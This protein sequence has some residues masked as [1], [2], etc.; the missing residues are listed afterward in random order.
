MYAS[1]LTVTAFALAALSAPVHA[2]TADIFHATLG[3]T[4]PTVDIST[5]EMRQVLEDG[6][7]LIIDTRTVAEFESGHIPGAKLVERT[8]KT[9]VATVAKITA[10]NKAAKLVLYCNGPYCQASRNLAH[11]L[12]AAGYTNVTRYQLGVP[13]WRALGGGPL[14]VEQN[15]VVQTFKADRTAIFVDTRSAAEFAKSTLPNALNIPADELAAGKLKRLPLPDDDFN[16]RIVLFGNDGTQARK[17]A[18]ALS[19]RP[20]HNVAYF[21]GRLADLHAALPAH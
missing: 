21:S 7:A 13:V 15:W 8:S 11:D 1:I 3:E 6:S 12:V 20:W 14:A 16:R 5:A 17:V 19:K 10:D 18:E 9:A 4:S 2:E